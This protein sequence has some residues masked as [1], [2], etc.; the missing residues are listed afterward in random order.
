MILRLARSAAAVGVLAAALGFA[1]A[2]QATSPA[3]VPVVLASIDDCVDY[4]VA[5]GGNE[6]LA[7]FACHEA[8]LT[9]CYRIF[10]DNYGPQQWAV[11]ACKLRTS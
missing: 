9:D 4:A 10:R 6:H 1:P 8:N 11:D 3:A 5:N 7:A 2:A